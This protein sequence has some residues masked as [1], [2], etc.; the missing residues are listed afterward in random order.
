MLITKKVKVKINNRYVKYYKELGYT[1]IKGGDEIEI[2]VEH[3][4]EKSH[5]KV[6]VECDNCHIQQEIKYYNYTTNI[7]NQNIYLCKKCKNIK[8]EK[9]NIKKYGVKTTLLEEKTQKKIKETLLNKYKVDHYSK[10]DE[11]KD[12]IIKINKDKY[13]VDYYFQS[14][15]YKRKRKNI[16]LE[17][18]GVEFYSQHKD[19]NKKRKNTTLKNYGVEHYSKSQEFREKITKKIINKFK[20]LNINILEKKDE[21]YI[22]KCEHEHVYEINKDLLKNRLR[23][24]VEICTICNPIDNHQS[25]KE[26]QLFKFIRE[27]YNNKI[28]K[29]DRKILSGKELDIY[30]PDL[31]LAFE[32]NGVFWHNE[33][34]K[35][36]KYHLNKTTL[37]EE[38]N[39]QLIHIWEDDWNYKQEIIKSMILNKLGKTKE[40]IM[41]RKCIIK[42]IDNNKSIR[43]FLDKN[44]LQS[45]IGSKVKLGLFYQNELV[46]LMTFGKKRIAMNS[47]SKENEYELLRF[48]NKL[49]TIVIGGASRLFKYFL[50][51]YNPLE[52]I[53]YTDRSHSNGNLYKQLGF[54][55][56]H[57][58][59]PNYYYVIDG[60]RKHR[61][62]FRK[63]KLIKEG[64]SAEK[65]EHQIMLDRKIYRIHDSGS[66]KYILNFNINI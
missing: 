30:L 63:D 26:N 16:F 51:N 31:N 61:F 56:I 35:E 57:K 37:C 46:S 4:S 53:T 33:L 28:I 62:N 32:F 1:N 43:Q 50:K 64:F 41:A 11:F 60:I 13:D 22:I 21:T 27:N 20:N 15:E 2:L 24:N 59:P 6:L 14:K 45:F 47:S 9:T 12:K 7:K 52:I 18:Y 65:T 19:Y 29:S 10:S 36:N 39:I 54:E 49:N 42:E 38:N 34:Y 5:N 25:N 55:F 40:K 8:T 66:L 48:C 17:K 58:T 23:F 44:H 3:L